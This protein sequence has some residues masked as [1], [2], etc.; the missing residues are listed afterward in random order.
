M[1]LHRVEENEPPARLLELCES[2]FARLVGTLVL[3]GCD[4][5]SAEDIAQETCTRL[6]ERW[7]SVSQMEAPESW[8]FRVAFNLERSRLRRL[9][10]ARRHS[11]QGLDQTAQSVPGPSADGLALRGALQALAL[12]QRQAVVLRYF[13][14]LNISE[15]ADVMGCA[16]GTVSALTHQAIVSLRQLLVIDMEE[17]ADRA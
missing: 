14:D 3:S 2:L 10:V 17:V 13:A 5:W 7:P 11:S 12:R 9:R 16:P 6:W 1:R 4:R 15:T 8:A